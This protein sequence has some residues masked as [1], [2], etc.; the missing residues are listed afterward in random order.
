MKK[1]LSSIFLFL[2][3][4]IYI[5]N[6]QDLYLNI[7]YQAGNLGKGANSLKN[8]VFYMNNVKY[9]ELNDPISY[10][11]F[12]HGI[13][14]ELMLGKLEPETVYFFWNWSNSHLIAKGNGTDQISAQNMDIAMKYRMNNLTLTAFGFKITD[15]LGIAYSPVDVGK[16]KVLYKNSGEEGSESYIDFYNVEKGFLS[17]YTIYGSSY[18]LDLFLKN[19]LRARFSY[20]KSW[21]GIDL[22]DREDVTTVHYYNAD[23]FHFSLAYMLRL[24]K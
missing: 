20:Y 22:R 2:F 12:V 10:P 17:D 9:P 14:I 15:W 4:S 21:S 11:G 8:E 3:I 13:D 18:Y 23:R 16:L 6:A 5:L 1:K 19:R 24:S 7:G